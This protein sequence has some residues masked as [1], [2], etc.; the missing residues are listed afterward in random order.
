M[1]SNNRFNDY[2]T[3]AIMKL[4]Y[5]K[6]DGTIARFFAMLI[7]AFLISSCGSAKS[8]GKTV[9]HGVVPPPGEKIYKKLTTDYSKII[10]EEE[11]I[12]LIGDSASIVPSMWYPTVNF[13]LR[14][15]NFVVL[16]HTAQS[17]CGATLKA[18]S[19]E[20]REVSSHYL[21]CKD[22]QVY[23]LCNDYLRTWHAGEGKWGNVED[24]NSCSIG[25]EIDNNGSEAFT[26]NQVS[27]VIVLLDSLQKKYNIP[28]ANIIGHSD[29]SPKRKQDPSAFFP[30]EKLAKR[31]F[32]YW[33]DEV[34]SSTPADFNYIYALKMIGYD[35]SD[36]KSAII[37]F[38]RH[39]IQNDLK[40]VLTDFD[41]Q[42]IYN[43]WG[44]YMELKPKIKKPTNLNG[45]EK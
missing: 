30:W 2:N 18:F 9:N 16:H 7:L 21:I 4:I 19:M 36:E 23:R 3:I 45:Q 27:S 24:M 40:S 34:L 29:F 38:K 5:K 33:R 1:D 35:I 41:K 13:N 8:I 12:L 17:S 15:P 37:A 10:K 26:D 31:N 22:G 39:F 28:Q 14:K 11:P 44:K 43:I 25:I 42:V 6:I 32:G 20:S